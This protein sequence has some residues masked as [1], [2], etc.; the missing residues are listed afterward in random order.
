MA[1]QCSPSAYLVLKESVNWDLDNVGE[2]M[3]S[4]DYVSNYFTNPTTIRVL[5]F[6][7][8]IPLFGHLARK[9]LFNHIFFVY[10]VV[11]NYLNAHDSCQAIAETVLYDYN[12]IL[13]E[14]SSPSPKR[15]FHVSKMKVRKIKTWLKV[16]SRIISISVSLK[17]T[18][19]SRSKRLQLVCLISKNVRLFI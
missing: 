8:R 11:I 13:K 14:Y 16:I 18:N 5:F 10:D 1:N 15:L 6:L 3:S 4:W 12:I 17:L 19:T 7:K 9:N 2:P